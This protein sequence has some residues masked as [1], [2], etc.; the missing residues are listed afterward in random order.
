M[1]ATGRAR[2]AARARRRRLPARARRLP[3]DARAGDDDERRRRRSTR[4][5]ASCCRPADACAQPGL[6]RALELLA[7]EGPRERV[8]RLAGHGAARPDGRARRARHPR[9]PHRLRGCVVGAGRGSVLGHARADARRARAAGDCLEALPQLRGRRPESGRSRSRARSTGPTQTGD[10]T[11]LVTVDAEGN[12]CVLTSSLGLGAGDW[13]PGLDLHL[14][15]M[16]G[17]ADLIREPLGPAQ[18]MGS[19][20]SPTLALDGDG[21]GTR[22]RRRRRHAAAQR[23]RPGAGR[24]AR[25][26]LSRHRRPSTGPRL[27]PA[28]G[29]VHLEPGLAGRGRARARGGRL[30]RA[31]LA[32]PAPLLRRCQRRHADG[33]AGDPRRSGAAATLPA[34]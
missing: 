16:L 8:R 21:L 7:D 23:A 19:M 3:G 34:R 30:R 27:H 28:A 33:A 29:V 22:R 10:T 6:V 11:N 4:R 32:G 9:R 15:S 13:L 20:M 18:R 31:R 5:K 2:A 1:G 26:G 24:D 25:R 14:N 12:A 17:E